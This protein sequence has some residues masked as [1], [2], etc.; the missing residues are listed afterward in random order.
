MAGGGCGGPEVAV[1]TVVH[2][3]VP[4]RAQPQAGPLADGTHQLPDVRGEVLLLGAGAGPW[5]DRG[6]TVAK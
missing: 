2:S 6:L 1:S 5:F 3:D 4:D